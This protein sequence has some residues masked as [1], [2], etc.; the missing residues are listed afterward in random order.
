MTATHRTSTAQNHLLKGGII[1]YPTEGVWGLGCD[2]F[3]EKA[4]LRILKLK[5]REVEKG[6]ILAASSLEQIG[7]LLSNLSQEHLSLLQQSCPGPDTWLIPDTD[8]K[9][10]QWIKGSFATVAVR[11]SAHPVVKKLCDELGLLVSTSANP[12]GKEPALSQEEVES[13]FS[14]E[15]LLIIPGELGGQD[16]P[17][18]IVDLESLKIIRE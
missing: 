2:P 8:Q 18:R 11:V 14:G 12:A 9:I 1:A 3:N 10:P 15:D 17:S 16:G 5:G 6:L 7:H 13:Y 4:V